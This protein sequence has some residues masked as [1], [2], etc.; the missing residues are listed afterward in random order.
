MG[1]IFFLYNCAFLISGSLGRDFGKSPFHPFEAGSSEPCY[2][3][4]LSK[5]IKKLHEEINAIGSQESELKQLGNTTATTAITTAVNS[6]K[7]DE[8][9][10]IV[11][12]CTG[13]STELEALRRLQNLSDEKITDLDK[14][15]DDLKAEN[16]KKTVENAKQKVDIAKHKAENAK[17]TTDISRLKTENAK[18]TTENAK[19]K[20]D[21]AK[22]KADL[23]EALK[24]KKKKFVYVGE[25]KT[26]EDARAD[27]KRRGGDL[28]SHLTEEDMKWVYSKVIPSNAYP[29]AWIGGR[30]NSRAT[31]ANFEGSFEWIDGGQI[32]ADDGNWVIGEP[33]GLSYK[34]MGINRGPYPR[35]DGTRG[36]FYGNSGCFD[37]IPF[38]CEL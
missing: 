21:I 3:V 22:L 4:C 1:L 8:L 33:D 13:S 2:G 18:L 27:C 24:N 36:P 25:S 11:Q 26:W 5:E 7:L 38:L 23:E 35:K 31:S 9:L 12:N 14:K 32:A 28:A 17:Q 19:Q 30:M 37:Y 10:Q 34:C 20:A 15:N 6:A 16:T 29:A